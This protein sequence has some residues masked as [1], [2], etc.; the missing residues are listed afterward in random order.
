MALRSSGCRF[1]DTSTALP[2]RALRYAHCM[3]AS[4]TGP[5]RGNPRI[6]PTAYATAAAWARYGF[7]EADVFDTRR[8]R[9]MLAALQAGTGLLSPFVPAV[10]AGPEL[11]RWRH[12]A[13]SNWIA[14]RAPRLAIEIGAGLS[15]R[16][17]AYARAHPE[18][19]W[20]DLDLPGMVLA[21]ERRSA[22]TPR[23]PNHHLAAGDL[24]D[25]DLGTDITA[26][27]AGPVVAVTEGVVDYLDRPGKQQAWGHIAALLARLGG[28]CYLTEVYPLR[29]FVGRGLAARAARAHAARSGATLCYHEDE[30]TPLLE[31]A[32]FSS[33]RVLPDA[34][35][36]E[37][38][39][40]SPA[41][42]LAF[43]LLEA[44]T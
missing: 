23:P 44:E 20:H 40:I 18:T 3:S 38:A 33:V 14:A 17:Q 42:T 27:A 30:V 41:R 9:A 8:G 25:P 13:F 15:T 24:F 26:P 19:T 37:L 2:G 1:D 12:D 36:A 11:L 21:R 7:A 29:R 32:G 31:A 28:G 43:S 4:N 10:A 35:V 16:G 39:G 34:E 6:S 5:R 22:G